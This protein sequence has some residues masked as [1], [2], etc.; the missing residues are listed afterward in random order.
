VRDHRSQ[1]TEDEM[2]LFTASR[3][4]TRCSFIFRHPACE[5]G[6][7]VKVP[8]RRRRC[9]RH[10]E[11]TKRRIHLRMCSSRRPGAEGD[12]LGYAPIVAPKTE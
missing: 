9:S 2:P 1:K 4:E 5:G 11:L 12:S 6:H 8:V 10:L 7:V 3:L